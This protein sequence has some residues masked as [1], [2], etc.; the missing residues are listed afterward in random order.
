M[1][2]QVQKGLPHRKHIGIVVIT[3]LA[4]IT[5]PYQPSLFVLF[6]VQIHV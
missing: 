1:V 5:Y 4:F 2:V 6:L 3:H